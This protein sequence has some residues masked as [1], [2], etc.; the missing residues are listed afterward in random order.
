MWKRGWR[1]GARGWKGSE[2][3]A[4]V[5]RCLAGGEVGGRRGNDSG[6]GNGQATGVCARTHCHVPRVCAV[7][8]FVCVVLDVCVGR[9]GY[10]PNFNFFVKK[11]G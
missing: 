2:R 11:T 3:N 1:G 9:A 7:F 6:R 4:A 8:V 5:Q 10:G